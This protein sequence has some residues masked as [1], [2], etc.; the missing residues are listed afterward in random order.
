MA[1]LRQSK[2]NTNY[3]YLRYMKKII[4]VNSSRRFFAND[5]H[6]YFLVCYFSVCYL[7]FY[8]HPEG[9]AALPR[10]RPADWGLL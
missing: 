7:P 8:F 10:R 6:F 9:Q 1:S 5:I 3:L 4:R 2:E